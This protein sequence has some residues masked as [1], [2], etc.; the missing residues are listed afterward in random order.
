M[1]VATLQRI[2]GRTANDSTDEVGRGIQLC[3]QM[4]V[5]LSVNLTKGR[6]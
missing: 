2:Y 6:F 5:L 1:S 3:D 4:L